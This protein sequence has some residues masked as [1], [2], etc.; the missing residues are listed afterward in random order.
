MPALSGSDHTLFCDD[1]VVSFRDASRQKFRALDIATVSFPP[2]LLH[3]VTGP[4]GSGKS[5]LLYAI[6]GLANI[7]AGS[8][9]YG[10]LILSELSEARRDAWRRMHVGMVF[11]TFNL[12]PELN[13]ED[14]V[15]LPAWFG[16]F[17]AGEMRRMRARGLLDRL[18][19][20]S[21]RGALGRL[22]R[23]EQQRVAIA[24]ALLFDP[25]AILADEPTASLD[26]EAGEAVIAMLKRMAVEEGRTV[27]AVS[28]DP[29]LIKQADNLIALERGQLNGDHPKDTTA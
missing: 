14:N 25:P 9:R 27:I 23:G 1:L 4:S 21:G 24:R 26:A 17:R 2:G 8:I 28:H 10:S 29:A 5:T 12:I 18:G 7:E 15:L 3:V 13:A 19:V 6:A 16:N 11:Q 20:P 22:S